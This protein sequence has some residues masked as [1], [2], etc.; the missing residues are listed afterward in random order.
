MSASQTKAQASY[1]PAGY[2]MSQSL[3]RARKP[4][5]TRNL[6][7]GGIIASFAFGTF[8]YSIAA[9]QQDDFADVQDLL[10]P[11]SERGKM[12]TIEEELEEK[13]RNN[14][15][16]QNL[17]NNDPSLSSSTPNNASRTSSIVKPSSSKIETVTE[18]LKSASPVSPMAPQQQSVRSQS[19]S[20]FM[21]MGGQSTADA[22]SRS[23]T[24][25]EEQFAMFRLPFFRGRT[26]HNSGGKVLPIVNGEVNVDNIGSIWDDGVKTYGDRRLV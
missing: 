8:W 21:I 16:A 26:P 25:E 3:K 11:A 6:L 5:L 18:A 20:P 24:Q 12:L 2:G 13:R 22:A 15:F 4:F 23:R 19:Q 1:H 10:P 17:S 9:V 7:T 14:P